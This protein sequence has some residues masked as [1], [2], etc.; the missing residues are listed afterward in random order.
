MQHVPLHLNLNLVLD[1]GFS[2]FSKTIS[3]GYSPPMELSGKVV[4]VT[5]AA[6]RV[7]KA[8]ATELSRAGARIVVH[9][10]NSSK[11]AEELV[12]ALGNACAIRADLAEPAGV[13]ALFAEARRFGGG[14]DVLV[15]SAA[16]FA[17]KPFEEIADAEW[18]GVLGLNLLA[19]ARC[20]REAAKDMRRRGAGVIV[21]ILDVGAFV[22]WRNYA[23]H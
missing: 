14:I 13:Q 21:N 16:S 9:H 12:Q 6:R 5:G 22:P 8:I 11:E 17:R 23:H 15:N 19:P 4:L 3:G 18:E 1:P 10:H 2:A 20:A 7:G